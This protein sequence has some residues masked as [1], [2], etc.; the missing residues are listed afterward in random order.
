VFVTAVYLVCGWGLVHGLLLL[1][2][3]L[4]ALPDWCIASSA[5]SATSP[6]AAE[7][8]R[9]KIEK[10]KPWQNGPTTVSYHIPRPITEKNLSGVVELVYQKKN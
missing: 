4:C 10:A 9:K 5:S 3:F 1:P 8:G 7:K 6:A 2:T